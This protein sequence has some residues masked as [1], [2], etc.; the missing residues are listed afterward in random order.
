MAM[1]GVGFHGGSGKCVKIWELATPVID[2]IDLIDFEKILVQLKTTI[3]FTGF[4][5]HNLGPKSLKDQ[6]HFSGFSQVA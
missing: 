3:D 6:R 2:L 1:P 5:N 4:W